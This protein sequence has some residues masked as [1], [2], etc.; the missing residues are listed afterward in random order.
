MVKQAHNPKVTGSN[1]VP[2]TKEFKDLPR[3]G[4]GP[5]L[6]VGYFWGLFFVP[7]FSRPALNAS[8]F[9]LLDQIH[10]LPY[11][12]FIKSGGD[13]A[14]TPGR[15]CAIQYLKGDATNVN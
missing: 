12:F 7:L 9:V 6:S 14:K 1:P 8:D 2:A 11:T 4:V 5:F 10:R 3:L 13:S 15:T